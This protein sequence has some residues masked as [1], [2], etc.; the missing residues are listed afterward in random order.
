MYDVVIFI[1]NFSRLDWRVVDCIVIQF[2]SHSYQSSKKAIK[3]N[4][5]ERDM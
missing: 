5:R 1:S 4:I 2:S 3:Y